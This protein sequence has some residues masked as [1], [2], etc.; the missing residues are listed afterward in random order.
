MVVVISRFYAKIV[1]IGM[2][3]FFGFALLLHLTL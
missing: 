2:T 3:D 1:T